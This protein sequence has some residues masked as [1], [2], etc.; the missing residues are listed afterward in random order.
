MATEVLLIE[1]VYNLGRSGDIVKVK[2]GYAR[3]YLL[4]Q[5]L[6]QVADKAAVRR[7]KEL[8]EAREKRAEEDR[9][10][11]LI[12]SEKLSPL[13]LETIVKVDH[14]GH[15]YGSV[16]SQDIVDLLASAHNIS[17][18]KHFVALKQPIKT[19]G[20]HRVEFKLKEGV[21]AALTL[22]VVAEEK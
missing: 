16:S 3:N 1:D 12:L 14:E 4:P 15:M 8:Q 18:D 9:K 2:P 20:V 6:A 7:Q 13:T 17:L 5:K 19:I 22:K 10:E 11:A 21:G